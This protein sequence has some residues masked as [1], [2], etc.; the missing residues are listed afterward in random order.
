MSEKVNTEATA[1]KV[2][3]ED[4]VALY[5]RQIRLWGLEA[6]QRMRNASI[7]IVGLSAL[8]NEVCKNLV[9][10]GIGSITIVDDK[11]VTREDLGAQFYISEES[12]GKNRAESAVEGLR[13]LNPRVKINVL[14][15]NIQTQADDF[16]TGF[17]IVVL[18]ECD[19]ATMKRINRLCHQAGTK[20][21]SA[22]TYGFFGYIFCDLVEHDYIED[23]KETTVSK[24]EEPEIKRVK[25]S[26]EFVSLE[27]AL[28][29]SWSNMTLRQIKKRISPVFFGIQLLWQFQ[30]AHQRLPTPEDTEEILSLRNSFLPTISV[31]T[32][33]L[34]DEFL[35]T[36]VLN[37]RADL[38]PVCA[39]VGGILAQEILKVLSAKELPV[40]NFFLY[41][42]LDGTGLV[43][44]VEPTKEQ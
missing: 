2:I 22:D 40:N 6:Q 42:G 9:L 25:K 3:S 11:S 13:N 24:N 1:S 7:L 35:T 32:S 19:L 15:E 26:E 4:E 28:S 41:N 16:F 14:A 10:A 29:K 31:D 38:T 18:T 21:Y 36:L 39:I 5:D 37:A 33:V 27:A 34:S 23:R 12:V 8:S 20:F 17:E 44:Q 43:H 30:E